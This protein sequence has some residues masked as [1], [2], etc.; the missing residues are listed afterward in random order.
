[1][2]KYVFAL[3]VFLHGLIHAMGFS[4]AF[5]YSNISHLSKEISKPLGLVWLVAAFLFIVAAIYFLINKN[6]W[7][8]LAILAVI[9]SQAVVFNSWKEAKYATIVNVVILIIA[10][11]VVAGKRF[12]NAVKKEVAELLPGSRQNDF[13]ITSKLL[14]GLP[15]IV[16]KWLVKSGVLG[17]HNVDFVR[18]KQV[19]EMRLKPG[20]RW[21]PFTATQYFSVKDPQFIWQVHVEMMPLITMDGR[22]KFKDGTGEMLI[23][24][25][26]VFKIVDVGKTPYMN[27]ASMVRYLAEITWFPTAALSKYLSWSAIDANRKSFHD[28]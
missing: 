13:F 8:T 2:L 14:E 9:F 23:K 26:A 1:M 19:G 15:A 7:E 25:L 6:N 21:M 18:L 17:K 5:N 4:K 3:L 20:G 22:D 10:V 12:N 27:A 28:L 24:L 16:Q 11:P